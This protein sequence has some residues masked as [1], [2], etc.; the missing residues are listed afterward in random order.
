MSG[1]NRSEQFESNYFRTQDGLKLHYR[2][3][4][5]GSA[6]Q[7]AAIF[8][9]V[10]L[11]GLTRNAR[12]FELVA[13]RLGKQYRVVCLDFRGRGNSDYA[14]DA[15]TYV[16]R[17]YVR[18]LSA[19]LTHLQCGPVALIG[20]SLGGLV[21]T[22]FSAVWPKKV[23]G[24]VLNDVGPQIDP[25]GLARIASYVGKSQAVVTWKDAAL[26]V[27][28]LDRGVY[29]D[30]EPADW[31]RTARRRYIE[32][33]DGRVRL[34]YDLSIA[35]SFATP[36]ATPRQWPFVRRLRRC[37]VMVIRGSVS[38]ILSRETA[39]RMREVI[40]GLEIVEIPDRGHTPTLEEPAA[41]AAI[42]AFLARLSP[43]ES[44]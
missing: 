1:A 30:Y 26:A 9:V 12:D 16:P 17:S 27:E 40:P 34:D 6:G 25:V 28:R 3:Y 42:S 24:L 21:G 15:L 14:A 4:A 43:K 2:D 35:K 29:P 38:D 37:P 23:L 39:L 31:I 19:L 22:M 36:A 5:H 10:C 8:P 44:S 11:P 41:Q 33:P 13:A 32:E 7:P 18:D 20:T